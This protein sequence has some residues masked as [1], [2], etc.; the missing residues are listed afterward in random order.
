MV[1]RV[2]G[3][4]GR[5][6]AG[7]VLKSALDVDPNLGGFVRQ[8]PFQ[9][10]PYAATITIDPTL[11]KFVQVGALTGNITVNAPTNPAAGDELT[12]S[13]VQDGVGGR[14]I[15]WNAVFLGTP[16]TVATA[17]TGRTTGRFVYNGTNWI[18]LSLA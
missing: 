5:Q 16:A 1:D 18:G 14:T 15:T 8:R 10:V 9:S 4:L 12:I 13:F 11:G 3:Y 6:P 7:Q 17:T 2:P